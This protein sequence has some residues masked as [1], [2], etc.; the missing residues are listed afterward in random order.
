[1]ELNRRIP[2]VL[3]RTYGVKDSFITSHRPSDIIVHHVGVDLCG[4][5]VL[6]AQGF[7]T[8]VLSPGLIYPF[9]IG[10]EMQDVSLLLKCP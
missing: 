1:M 3:L 2:L 10:V 9:E 8:Q 5:D 7:L 4:G 6:V